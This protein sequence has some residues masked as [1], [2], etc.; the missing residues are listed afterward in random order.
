MHS[1]TDMVL[2]TTPSNA[3]IHTAGNTIYT[4]ESKKYKTYQIKDSDTL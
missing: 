2:I 4:D 1:P 3:P